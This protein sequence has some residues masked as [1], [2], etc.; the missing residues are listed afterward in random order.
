M[1]GVVFNLQPCNFLKNYGFQVEQLLNRYH[2]FPPQGQVDS[3]PGPRSFHLTL[4]SFSYVD[5]SWN[6]NLFG[7]TVEHHHYHSGPSSKI[8]P[9]ETKDQKE[10]REAKEKKEKEERAN[11]NSMIVG[12][13]VAAVFGYIFGGQCQALSETQWKLNNLDKERRAFHNYDAYSSKTEDLQ[14]KT[15]VNDV[16][17]AYEDFYA[18]KITKLK[19]SLMFSGMLLIEA[20]CLAVSSFYKSY[21]IRDGIVVAGFLTGMAALVGYAMFRGS[22]SEEAWKQK[23]PGLE[24]EINKIK[25]AI[26]KSLPQP[27]SCAEATGPRGAHA[28]SEYT[29]P[30]IEDGYSWIQHIP[31]RTWFFWDVHQNQWLTGNRYWNRANPSAPTFV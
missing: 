8:P 26:N 19:V 28:E 27:P 29:H 4:P 23:Y 10:A 5:N 24:Q 31:T 13:V 7:R 18:R 17:N 30:I 11:K 14:A 1:D 22:D 12:G 20:V 2:P 3:K 9:N 25:E 21:R 6:W 15:S 16:W